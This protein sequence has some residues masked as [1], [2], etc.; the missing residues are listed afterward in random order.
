MKKGSMRLG[1]VWVCWYV[2]E[3]N[4]SWEAVTSETG[5]LRKGQLEF[6]FTLGLWIMFLG[7]KCVN[8]PFIGE[9]NLLFEKLQSNASFQVI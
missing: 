7:P 9:V 2:Y 3:Q 4:F 8:F 6:W 1:D 5:A